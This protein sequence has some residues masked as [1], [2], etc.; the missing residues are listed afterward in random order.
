MLAGEF[1]QLDVVRALVEAKANLD[2]ADAKGETALTLAGDRGNG[3]IVDFLKSSGAKRTDVHIIDKGKPDPPLQPMQSWALAVGAIYA[4]ISGLNTGTLGC[5]DTSSR[6]DIKKRLK[7]DWDI[8]S[9]Y[10]FLKE[11]D[12]LST[13]GHRSGYQRNGAELA[14]LSDEEFADKLASLTPEDAAR[15]RAMRAN[16]P[17]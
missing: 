9:K 1:D 16:W 17:A 13:R 7:D 3:D 4:Q 5:G 15:A 10:T 6:N 12:D 11:I 8:T 2:L 14:A